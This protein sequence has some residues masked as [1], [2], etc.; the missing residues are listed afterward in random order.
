MSGATISF[1][2][3]RRTRMIS[4]ELRRGINHESA[5]PENRGPI[6]PILEPT[7]YR[8]G[9]DPVD[10]TV[11]YL[12]AK[13]LV[14]E[15]GGEYG[16]NPM[17]SAAAREATFRISGPDVGDDDVPPSPRDALR[18]A[19]FMRERGH[20]VRAELVVG[21]NELRLWV[22]EGPYGQEKL[23]WLQRLPSQEVLDEHDTMVAYRQTVRA[24]LVEES[25]VAT[26]TTNHVV[27]PSVSSSVP[28]YVPRREFSQN[29]YFRGPP[30]NEEELSE[31]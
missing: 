13:E 3:A 1:A 21:R 29:M 18:L 5:Y 23:Y 20:D 12:I 11:N 24:T 27:V 7:S 2:E 25:R 14:L 28:A 6:N 22:A 8:A 10:C 31:V 19:Y 4:R 15:A 16:T 30:D 9:H 26:S 17:T